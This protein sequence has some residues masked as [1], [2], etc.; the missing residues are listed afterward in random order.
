[1]AE[2]RHVSRQELVKNLKD[3]LMRDAVRSIRQKTLR[4]VLPASHRLGI[5]ESLTFEVAGCR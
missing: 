5:G 1:M 2:P 4:M 3:D